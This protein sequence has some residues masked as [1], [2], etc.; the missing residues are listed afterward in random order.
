MSTS[1]YSPRR[2]AYRAQSSPNR[3]GRGARCAPLPIVSVVPG[4]SLAGPCGVPKVTFEEVLS[5]G[6]SGVKSLITNQGVE[7]Q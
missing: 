5:Q 2:S 3:V 6:S 4:K 1:A 7:E